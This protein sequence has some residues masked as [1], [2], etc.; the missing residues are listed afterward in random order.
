MDIK[1][2]G[3]KLIP[4]KRSDSGVGVMTKD[5]PLTAV[6]IT[7]GIGSM[8]LGARQAGFDVLGNLEWRKYYHAKDEQGRNTITE[9]FRRPG[10]VFK[11]KITNLS[12]F[13]PF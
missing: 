7:C 8:L 9:N 3:S 5:N 2:K 12:R 11:E 13:L 6:C 4:A 1:M 10:L